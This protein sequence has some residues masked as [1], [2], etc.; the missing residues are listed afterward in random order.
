MEEKIA[1]IIKLGMMVYREEDIA[2]GIARD[3]C[4]QLGLKSET[5]AI[6]IEPPVI[7]QGG[8]RTILIDPPWDIRF[9]ERKVRP[10]QKL[11]Y[12]GTMTIEEITKLPVNELA[13][14]ECDLFLWTTQTYLPYSFEILKAWGFKYHITLTWNKR[15]G[16]TQFG[17]HRRTE[18]CLYA[19]KNKLSVEK[20]GNAIPTHLDDEPDLIDEKSTIHSRKPEQLYRLIEKK[21]KPPRLELFARSKRNDWHVWGNQV[22][23]DIS[24]DV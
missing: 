8:Y 22:E 21:C 12:N 11:T 19:Y 4:N 16:L 15:N 3:I 23:S 17:F 9:I 1:E 5:K 10:N 7:R 24:L 14:D 13:A 2:K 20:T 6:P 18:F